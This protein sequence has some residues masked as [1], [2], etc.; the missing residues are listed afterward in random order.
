M[1]NDVLAQDCGWL[2]IIKIYFGIICYH[3]LQIYPGN[4]IGTHLEK[5]VDHK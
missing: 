3:K 5:R 4:Q 2:N 1:Y